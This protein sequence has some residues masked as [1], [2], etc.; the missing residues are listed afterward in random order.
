MT[1]PTEIA[2][3][4]PAPV[5][6]LPPRYGGRPRRRVV[7]IVLGTLFALALLAWAIWAGLASGDQGI[8]ASVTSYRV[9]DSHQV[10]VKISAHFKDADTEG[11]CLVRATAADH[12]IVGELNI[13]ADELRANRGSWIP[14]RTE[15]R[16]TT[17]EL[18]RCS[19]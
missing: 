8:D 12:T 6:S 2:A 18:V 16:A 19:D 10:Q 7:P 13:T 14:I 5:P 11:T 9:V 4:S 17:A 1:D 3:E 15:R